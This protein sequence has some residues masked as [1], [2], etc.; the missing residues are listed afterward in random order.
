MGGA[1]ITNPALNFKAT[2]AGPQ[3]MILFG[4]KNAGKLMGEGDLHPVSLNNSYPAS[5][6][7]PTLDKRKKGGVILPHL[8]HQG[9]V[10][11]SPSLL[12]APR[13]CPVSQKSCGINKA[14]QAAFI[15][16]IQH[17]IGWYF[18]KVSSQSNSAAF[19]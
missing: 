12:N 6:S 9:R 14:N 2:L 3:N 7:I 13:K 19:I 1:Q 15:W 8:T 16:P 4:D 18:C 5:L 17:Q 10:Q 11:M